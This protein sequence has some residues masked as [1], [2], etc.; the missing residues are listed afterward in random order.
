MTKMKITC[1][2]RKFLKNVIDTLAYIEH[3]EQAVIQTKFML[4]WEWEYIEKKI[5]GNSVEFDVDY[6]SV[7]IKW[8]RDKEMGRG[9]TKIEQLKMTTVW[10]NTNI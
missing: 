3:F 6:P 9:I 1:K 10:E 7:I 5:I 8:F 4:N 2:N